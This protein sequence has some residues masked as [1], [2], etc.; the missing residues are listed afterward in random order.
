MKDQSF[1]PTYKLICHTNI[2]MKM[3]WNFALTGQG[4]RLAARSLKLYALAKLRSIDSCQNGTLEDHYQI[5]NNEGS[6]TRSARLKCLTNTRSQRSFYSKIRHFNELQSIDS[7]QTT[8]SPDHH[9]LTVSRTQVSAYRVRVFL[10]LSA[11][12]LLLSDDWRL[13]FNFFNA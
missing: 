13:K 9:H 5:T 12:K 4:C 8:P 2:K 3:K 7:C 11:G 1:S 6:K 10:K